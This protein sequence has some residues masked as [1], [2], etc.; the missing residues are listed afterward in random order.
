MPLSSILKNKYRFHLGF[1]RTSHLKLFRKTVLKNSVGRTC[2]F[3]NMTVNFYYFFR[4]FTGLL[5]TG[6]FLVTVSVY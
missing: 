4:D 1:L 2:K 6:H 3:T 5:S